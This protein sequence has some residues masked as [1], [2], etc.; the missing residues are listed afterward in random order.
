MEIAKIVLSWLIPKSPPSGCAEHFMDVF[1]YMRSQ[2]FVLNGNVHIILLKRN[3][4]E[5]AS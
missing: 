4:Q 5:Q 1:G 2:L 3:L